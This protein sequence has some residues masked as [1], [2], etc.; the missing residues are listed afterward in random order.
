MEYEILSWGEM[1][2]R[3]G[4]ALQRGMH[5]R[6]GRWDP[7]YSLL[8]ASLRPGGPYADHSDE[9]RGALYYQG[10]DRWR[11]LDCPDP[12]LVD[13]PEFT[14]QGLRTQN[15]KFYC[16]ALEY[17]HGL[18]PAERVKVYQKILPG[19]WVD[20]G[21]HRLIDA[22]KDRSTGRLIFLF[23]L[24]R[25]RTAPLRLEQERTRYIPRRVKVAVWKRD[26]GRCV[27]CGGTEGLHFDHVVPYSRGGASNLAANVQLLCRRH[28]VSKADAIQ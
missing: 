19:V 11:A 27:V 9:E 24:E 3:E 21:L 23:K 7:G 12:L 14:V 28:N 16:A 13:Q 2:A 20:R 17:K 22:R 18:A 4:R 1:C 8:L 15:G 10:H 26:Q 6:G 25:E 5:F